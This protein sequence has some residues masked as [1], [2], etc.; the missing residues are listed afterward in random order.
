[1]YVEMYGYAVSY[2]NLSTTLILKE[3]RSADHP[4]KKVLLHTII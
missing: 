2:F 1:M 3:R 4:V